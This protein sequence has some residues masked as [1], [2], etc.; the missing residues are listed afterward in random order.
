[1]GLKIKDDQENEFNLINIDSINKRTD[2]QVLFAGLGIYLSKNRL[3]FS[4]VFAW[5][6]DFPSFCCCC[7][8]LFLGNLLEAIES[9]RLDFNSGGGGPL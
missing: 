3:T 6:D 2:G 7:Y 5:E 8:G 9:I 4:F 1:M